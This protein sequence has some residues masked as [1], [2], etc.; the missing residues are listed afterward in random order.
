MTR[1]IRNLKLARFHSEYVSPLQPSNFRHAGALILSMSYATL[2]A[3]ERSTFQSFLLC[4][5]FFS[6][7]RAHVSPLL[8]LAR[9]GR[10]EV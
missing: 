2:P 3:R 1:G 5:H 7:V 6:P 4:S 9:P 10:Q 8:A